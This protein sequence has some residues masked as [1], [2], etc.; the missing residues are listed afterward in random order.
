ME[1]FYEK[2]DLFFSIRKAA[3]YLVVAI[4]IF[5]A[6]Y[7]NVQ[8]KSGS[9]LDEN[10]STILR[11]HRFTGTIETKFKSK[12]GRPIAQ[13]RAKLGLMLKSKPHK[14]AYDNMLKR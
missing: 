8:A 14:G 1:V 4:S 11:K 6:G 7:Q 10:L 13:E 2:P 9:S 3:I 12:L 5:L